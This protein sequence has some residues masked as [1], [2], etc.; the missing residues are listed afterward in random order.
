M[1]RKIKNRRKLRKDRMKK[2]KDWKQNVTLCSLE[3][4]MKK[5]KHREGRKRAEEDQD[6][7]VLCT[8]HGNYCIE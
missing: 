4:R 1:K 7:T 8:V 5:K 6:W 2:T 3:G